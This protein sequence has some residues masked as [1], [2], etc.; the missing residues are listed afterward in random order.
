MSELNELALKLQADKATIHSYIPVYESL[1]AP[2]R[3]SEFNLLEI[4]VG[5]RGK[6]IRMWLDY[7]PKANIYGIDI[8]KAPFRHDRFHFR[9]F[10]INNTKEFRKYSCMFDVII[11]DASHDFVHQKN[12]LK[13]LWDKLKPDGTYCIEDIKPDNLSKFYCLE[14]DHKQAIMHLFFE[15]KRKDDHLLVVKKKE[16]PFVLYL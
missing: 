7:F 14:V 13:A 6:S 4:G 9:R 2:M 3:F 12:A 5:G 1:F 11:D 10:D 8:N 15:K 16:Q